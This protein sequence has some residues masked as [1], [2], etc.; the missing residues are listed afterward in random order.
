MRAANR[1]GAD[2]SELPQ[3]LKRRDCEGGSRTWVSGANVFPIRAMSAEV[4]GL[5]PFPKRWASKQQSESEREV[6]GATVSGDPSAIHSLTQFVGGRAKWPEGL[7][8]DP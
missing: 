4:R 8:A 2:A 5:N 3:G 1:A 7:V 6:S